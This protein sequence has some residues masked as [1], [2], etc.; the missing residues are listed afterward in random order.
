MYLTC[1]PLVK[2]RQ[3]VSYPGSTFQ[4]RFNEEN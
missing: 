4:T 3:F 1:L 2:I